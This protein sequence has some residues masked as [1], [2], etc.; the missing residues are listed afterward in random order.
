MRGI[1]VC[2]ISASVWLLVGCATGGAR[3]AEPPDPAQ[4]LVLEGFSFLPP[5]ETGWQQIQRSLFGAAFAKQGPVADESYA[6]QAMLLRLP[7]FDSDA[8]FLAYSIHAVDNDTDPGRF[9]ILY[10]DDRL[11]AGPQG[12][13]V[14]YVLKARDSD[15]LTV[16]G[17]HAPM[18]LEVVSFI[19]R[20]PENPEIGISLSYSKRYD[21]SGTVEDLMPAA[22]GLFD[23]LRFTTL[24]RVGAGELPDAG[25]RGE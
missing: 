20:H 16:S 9:K 12:N 3:H 21:Q 7:R 10:N 11:V 24:T 17:R 18:L 19:C 4:P 2:L 1:R 22:T 5:S 6:I 23:S 14:R 25:N 13:C 8:A 15:P